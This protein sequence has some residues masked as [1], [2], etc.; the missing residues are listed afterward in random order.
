MALA[1]EIRAGVQ[2]AFGVELTSEP[3]LVGVGW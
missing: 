1:R 2:A 3:V